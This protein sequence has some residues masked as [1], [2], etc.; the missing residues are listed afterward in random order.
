MGEAEDAYSAFQARDDD[1][2]SLWDLL[3]RGDV[4][5]VYLGGLATDYCVKA[6]ALDAAARGFATTVLPEGIRAVDLHPGDGDRAVAEMVA[7]VL[8][9]LIQPVEP[10]IGREFI[11]RT[12]AITVLGGMKSVWGT[13]A[14]GVILGV[15]EA[16]TSTYYGPS[17]APAVAFGVLLIAQSAMIIAFGVTP[18]PEPG[19]PGPS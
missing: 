17:L 3:R 5:H 19:D 18:Q 2:T 8:L 4:R 10:S 7:G 9:I 15:V 11:G 13:L 1:G 12:F 16:L 6:T 14:G